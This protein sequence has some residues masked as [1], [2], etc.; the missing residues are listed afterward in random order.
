M[1]GPLAL[2]TVISRGPYEGYE[3]DYKYAESLMKILIQ[4]IIITTPI[5]YLLTNYLGPIL[6]KKPKKDCEN[7]VEQSF[8]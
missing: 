7:N 3:T 1:L 2:T 5:G 4:A 6:L 8:A